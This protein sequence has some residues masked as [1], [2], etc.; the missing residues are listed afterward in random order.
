MSTILS[1]VAGRALTR[2]ILARQ[3]YGWL[4]ASIYVKY[5]AYVKLSDMYM[6]EG[7]LPHLLYNT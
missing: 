5:L 4:N 7:L 6:F 3:S 2:A 1:I